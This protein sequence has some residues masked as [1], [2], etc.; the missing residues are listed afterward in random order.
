MLGITGNDLLLEIYEGLNIHLQVAKVFFMAQDKRTGLVGYE[1]REILK[2]LEA[3]DAEGLRATLREH[4][5]SAKQ[6]VVAG[7][8]AQYEPDEFPT[9]R[10]Q[11]PV[12]TGDRQ[13]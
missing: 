5:Q 6:A 1:H 12:G 2:A 10:D 9:P 11:V 3:Q 4:I 13:H 7:I 8:D